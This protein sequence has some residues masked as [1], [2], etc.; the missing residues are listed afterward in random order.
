[1]RRVI[2]GLIV[3]L[4]FSVKAEKAKVVATTTMIA[5]MC[6]QIAGDRID[7]ISMM[8]VGGDPH[9]YDPIPRDAQNIA[10]ADLI[11]K[12]GLS[13]EGW[14][15]KLIANAPENALIVTV[16]EGVNA[17]GSAEYDNAYDPHA[18]MDVQNAKVYVQNIAKALIAIDPINETFYTNRLNTYLDQLEVLDKEVQSMINQIPIESRILITSHDAFRYFGKAY[19]LQVESIIGTSTEAEARIE[20]INHIINVIASHNIQAV[21]V[22]STINPKLMQQ[23]SKDH[24]VSIGGRLFADSLDDPENEAGTYIGMIR[25]NTKTIVNGLM[26]I[27]HSNTMSND[28]LFLLLLTVLFIGAF[29]FMSTKVSSKQSKQLSFPFHLKVNDLSTSYDQKR[30]LNNVN[31]RFDSG[32]IYGVIGPNGSGKSTL[33]KSILDLI[34]IDNGDISIN[35]DS[36][37]DYRSL[38]AYIPQK[39]EVDWTFPVTVFDLV[40]MGRY[41]HK[42]V[43]SSI[44]DTDKEMAIAA[45]K[46][47]DI[48]HLKDR[49]IGELSGG[50]QQRAFIARAVCQ[51]ADVFL[52]DEPFVGVDMLTEEKIIDLLKAISNQGKL[53]V[54]IHHDLSKVNDYFEEIVLLNRRIVAAGKVESVFNEE[55]IQKTFSSQLPILQ[56]KDSYIN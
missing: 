36:L 5:D 16:T 34:K 13:L 32:K 53:I 20:D 9:L 30:I 29:L 2:L 42:K 7:L 14:L 54:I 6:S 33:F 41:P 48:D 55:N 12:N 25:W 49:Q 28:D 4:S 52:M 23:L 44:S 37:K 24:E 10:K 15:D 51:D 18:W 26:N 35:D 45:M 56:E 11:L 27:G 38:I 17:I 22:E 46:Q 21:F 39:E 43:F 8:P 40:L 3:L 19:G 47:L 50:Q 31:L 1:M